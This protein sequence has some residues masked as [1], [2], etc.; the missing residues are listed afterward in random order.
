MA[1]WP[2]ATNT[3]VPDGVV[4]TKSGSI[5]ITKPGTVIDALDIQ[6]TINIQA[7]N[8]TIK[9]SKVTSSDFAVIRIA[10]GVT[11]TVIQNNDINGKDSGGQGIFGQGT[12]IGNDISGVGDGINVTGDKV[13]IQDN[14]IHDLGGPASSHYDGIQIDGGVSDIRIEHNTV[15]N[16]HDQTSA[17]MIDDYFGRTSNVVVNNNLLTG[18]GYTIYVTGLDGHGTD[19]VTV[20]NNHMGKGTYGYTYFAAANPVYSGNVNDGAALAA[21]LGNQGPNTGT[22]PTEL[23]T[24]PPPGSTTATDGADRLTGDDKD[25][26]I[27]GKGGNDIIDGRGGNDTIIGGAGF[28]TM[29]GGAGND[30]FV[31]RSAS[32]IGN[33]PG[34]RD[35]ITDFTPGQDKIDLSAIDA[36][37]KLAGNQEFSFIAA[38]NGSFTKTP[39]ELAWHTESGK[40]I[41]QGDIDGDGIHDFEIELKG[42]L[43]LKASDFIGV[44][45][46]SGGKPSVPDT[47]VPPTDTLLKITG[48]SGADKLVGTAANEYLDGQAGNDT[49]NGGGGNDV[50]YGGLGRDVMTGGAGNDVFLFKSVAEMGTNGATR[51]IITD[52]TRGQDKI[53]LSAID[54]NTKLSGDQAFSFLAGDNQAFTKT[55]GELAWHYEAAQNRTIVQGDING[56]GIHDFEIQLTGRVPLTAGDFIL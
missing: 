53:D 5:T 45:S 54:A 48:T 52:F 31:F 28:D 19:N 10:P 36:N 2:D 46:G 12:F 25:N 3:G 7:N 38:N 49:L 44:G 40:T 22:P 20:T 30:I 24:T 27:D 47:S 55:A 23:P 43:N 9:N 51:D 42:V 56:D 8:V 41:V 13:L 1:G 35:I 33:K 18:G 39:G 14:Y 16:H 50:L 6:G 4:L 29:T 26:V 15:I 11:G 17:V 37:T 32:E 21:Q 34:A